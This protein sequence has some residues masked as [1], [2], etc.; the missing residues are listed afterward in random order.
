MSTYAA[1]GQWDYPPQVELCWLY[2][3]ANDNVHAEALLACQ[4]FGCTVATEGIPILW[5]IDVSMANSNDTTTTFAVMSSTPDGRRFLNL[6]AALTA[7]L[8]IEDGAKALA[9]L[10]AASV[11]NPQ[12]R[13]PSSEHLTMILEA[14]VRYLPQERNKNLAS[15]YSAAARRHSDPEAVGLASWIQDWIARNHDNTHDFIE[16]DIFALRRQIKAFLDWCQRP[17]RKL[18]NDSECKGGSGA[19]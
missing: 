2:A 12:Q 5:G 17:E 19:S 8:S 1:K 18:L 7:F 4:G 6:A 10:M 11:S 16:D 15:R 13:V 14:L 3:A 9:L